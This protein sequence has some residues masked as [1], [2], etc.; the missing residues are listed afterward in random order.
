MPWSFDPALPMSTRL[1]VARR[2]TRSRDCCYS[3]PRSLT[4]NCTV[5]SSGKLYAEF[6]DE[7]T[8]FDADVGPEVTTGCSVP[9]ER[10]TPKPDLGKCCFAAVAGYKCEKD[11]CVV[12]AGGAPKEDCEKV[13]G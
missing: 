10:G 3:L 12:S 1:G 6:W 5:S 2:L 7:C 11:K 9:G 13:C 4:L 8:A